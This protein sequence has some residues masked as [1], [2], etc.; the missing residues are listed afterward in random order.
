MLEVLKDPLYCPCPQAPAVQADGIFM[1]IAS[2]QV[3]ASAP[4]VPSCFSSIG[5]PE[6]PHLL[7][8]LMP[9]RT[10]DQANSNDQCPAVVFAGNRKM[11][12]ESF[13]LSSLVD[14]QLLTLLPCWSAE[15]P[16]GVFWSQV[17]SLQEVALGKERVHCEC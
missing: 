8:S 3:T 13:A 11:S 6:M 1:L 10:T 12:Q 4:Q 17:S 2:M 5:S 9:H 15:V 16:G 14:S 7:H